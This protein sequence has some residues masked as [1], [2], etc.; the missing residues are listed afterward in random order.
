[1]TWFQRTGRGGNYKESKGLLPE[2]EEEEVEGVGG[3]QRG[4]R[5]SAEGF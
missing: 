5:P 3:T 2:E 1:M 4:E